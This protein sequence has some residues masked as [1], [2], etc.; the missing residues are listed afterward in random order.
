MTEEQYKNYG[1]LIEEKLLS[2]SLYKM[3]DTLLIYVSYQKEVPTHGIIK[4]A[5][6]LGKHV[7][8]PKVLSSGI[9]EFY[10]IASLEDIVCGYKNIPEPM[11][12]SSPY[13]QLSYSNVLMVMPLVG[14]DNN[15]NRIG[16]GG[17]FYD[18]Y[19]QNSHAMIRVALAYEC[20]KYECLLPIEEN[21]MKPDFIMT[22]LTDY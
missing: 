22:E 17:G 5:L 18:R 16:Y 7:F 8:C 3:A 1:K 19:L 10:E 14:F 15:K 20:Q 4:N 2:S 6:S 13:T 11:N 9:M 12:L 21:D